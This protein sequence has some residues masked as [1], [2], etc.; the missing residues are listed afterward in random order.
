MRVLRFVPAG[1]YLLGLVLGPVVLLSGCGDDTKQTGTQV[2]IDMAKEEQK[3]KKM[4]DFYK[5]K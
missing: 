4:E 5:K 1:I 3:R 2:P